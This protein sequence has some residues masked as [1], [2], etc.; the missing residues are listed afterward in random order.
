MTNHN[1]ESM[2]RRGVAKWQTDS[3]VIGALQV[4]SDLDFEYRGKYSERHIRNKEDEFG[5]CS[6][7]WNE[8]KLKRSFIEACD[9][10]PPSTQCCGLMND[11]KKTIQEA[12]SLLNSGWVK[13]MNKN[14]RSDG[15]KISCYAWT[16]HNA[17]GKAET[18][19]LLIRFHCLKTMRKFSQIQAAFGTGIQYSSAAGRLGSQQS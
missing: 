6:R 13:A 9:S 15:F 4:P 8:R 10:I 5:E 3:S 18:T 14:I 17:T 12:A 11:S 19:V 7:F 16:W 2:R 1:Q